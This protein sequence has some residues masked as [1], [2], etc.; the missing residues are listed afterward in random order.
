[1]PLDK[2]ESHNTSA[3]LQLFQDEISQ[4]ENAVGLGRISQKVFASTLPGSPA[5]KIAAGRLYLGDGRS[6]FQLDAW[7]AWGL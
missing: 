5:G 6:L 7:I 4:A 2:A 3:F 1:M